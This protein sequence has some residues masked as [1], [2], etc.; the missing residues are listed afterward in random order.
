[1]RM[2]RS[3]ALAWLG[4]AVVAVLILAAAVTLSPVTAALDLAALRLVQVNA[5]EPPLTEWIVA[6]TSLADTD[7]VVIV[8]IVL[9]TALTLLRHWHGALV[10]ALSV[11]L[12]QVTVALVKDLVSRPRPADRYAVGEPSGFSFP[13]GHSATSV[14]LYATVALIAAGVVTGRAR[15]AIVAAGAAVV[16]VV[17]AS[18]VY[19]GAHFPTDVLAGWLT[20]AAV[21][22]F[23]WALVS[24]LRPARLANRP[25]AG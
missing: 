6:V 18:R 14:A 2:L 3:H 25:A 1:M 20:G 22:A 23:S 5:V 9:A 10:L 17:G 8:T 13:S 15:L 24:R 11:A 4:L 21:V 19:L 12:T 16:L 7:I